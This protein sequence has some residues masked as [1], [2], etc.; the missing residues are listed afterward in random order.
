[1]ARVKG[2][3]SWVESCR[4][5]KVR[6]DDP[7]GCGVACVAMITG[8]E[9]AA[10]RQLFL[11][12]Q[13]GTRKGRPLATNFTELQKALAL[14]GVDCQ[15]KRFEGWDSIQGVGILAVDSRDGGNNSWH[16]VVVERHPRYGVV[17]HDPDFPLPSFS[18]KTPAGI[19]SH[20]FTE[21][22]ARKS[23]LCVTDL[24]RAARQT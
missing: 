23:W 5:R 16:R 9:Y 4:V 13:I 12:A 15:R 11:D 20:P 10:V 3:G 18:D 21:Y 2:D 6:Q 14:L 24:A 7:L 17:L 1:M 8:R 19:R 22:Q